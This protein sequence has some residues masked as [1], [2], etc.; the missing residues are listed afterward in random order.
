VPDEA[1]LLPVQ[2]AAAACLTQISAWET[3][4]HE[5][6]AGQVLERCYVLLDI[7]LRESMRE[8]R[9]GCWIVLAEKDRF[10]AAALQP[11]LEAT[12]AG[13]ET[14]DAE[15]AHEDTL[16]SASSDFSTRG[17]CSDAGR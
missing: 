8:Y 11:K 17:Y 6:H 7:D 16:S 14:G 13:E 15:S 9:L 12:D 5:V 1:R 2:A 4:S 3:R 10:M